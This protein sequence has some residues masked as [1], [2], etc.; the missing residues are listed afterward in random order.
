VEKRLSISSFQVADVV[1]APDEPDTLAFCRKDIHRSGL[2]ILLN[3]NQIA[4]P[5]QVN[6]ITR[7]NP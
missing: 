3:H 2:K 6:E 7:K 4:T 5:I 1:A